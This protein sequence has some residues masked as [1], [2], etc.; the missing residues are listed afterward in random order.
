MICMW[1]KSRTSQ[2]KFNPTRFGYYAIQI[3][4]ELCNGR[5]CLFRSHR[6]QFQ[7]SLCLFFFRKSSNDGSDSIFCLFCGRSGDFKLKFRMR[8]LTSW[9]LSERC[10]PLHNPVHDIHTAIVMGL[11]V[12]GMWPSMRIVYLQNGLRP[13]GFISVFNSAP[14]FISY[15]HL[16]RKVTGHLHINLLHWNLQLP[17]FWRLLFLTIRMTTSFYCTITLITQH[18]RV[19]V[20]Q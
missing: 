3:S 13:L 1:R 11:V 4:S 19:C 14:C 12:G 6:R 17:K 7:V 2:L 8:C 10:E 20:W 18:T 9:V 16:V 15:F 5:G